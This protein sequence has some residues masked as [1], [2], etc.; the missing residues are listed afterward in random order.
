MQLVGFPIRW[1]VHDVIR[2]P[3]VGFFIADDMFPI[4]ALPDAPLKRLPSQRAYSRDIFDC[5]DGFE[6]PTMFPNPGRV[7]E[8]FWA[9][10]ARAGP[11]SAPSDVA[12][13][14]WATTRVAQY[15]FVNDDDGVEMVRHDHVNVNDRGRKPVWYGLPHGLHHCSHLIQPHGAIHNSTKE[16]R[17]SLG[18]ERDK[19]CPRLAVIITRQADGPPVMDFRIIDK[20]AGYKPCCHD[21]DCPYSH[22]S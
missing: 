22:P 19:I 14:A 8:P 16:R 3:R 11:G 7:P 6:R 1:I 18:A 9:T 2:N 4:I 17:A 21:R 5:G 12:T 15:S 13:S 10:S 20:E